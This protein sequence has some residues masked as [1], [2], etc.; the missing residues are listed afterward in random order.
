[1]EIIRKFKKDNHSKSKFPEFFFAVY[2]NVGGDYKFYFAHYK[3][4]VALNFFLRLNV[5]NSM[6][7]KVS[8]DDIPEHYQVVKVG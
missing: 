5:D 1:M 6:L 7:V 3:Y 8:R 4:Y 2:V